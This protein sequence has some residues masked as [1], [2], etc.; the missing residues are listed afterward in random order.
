MRTQKVIYCIKAPVPL[1]APPHCSEHI[2]RAG[3]H[4]AIIV[5]SSAWAAE[6]GRQEVRAIKRAVSTHV[7]DARRA[8]MGLSAD[9]AAP[10]ATELLGNTFG[11]LSAAAFER[12]DLPERMRA[13]VKALVIMEALADESRL[14]KALSKPLNEALARVLAAAHLTPFLAV[15]FAVLVLRAAQA[16]VLGA[17]LHVLCALLLASAQIEYLSLATR[18]NGRL[19]RAAEVPHVETPPQHM[20]GTLLL[21]SSSSTSSSWRRPSRQL[22]LACSRLVCREAL[23]RLSQRCSPACPEWITTWPSTASF[24]WCSSAATLPIWCDCLTIYPCSHIPL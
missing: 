19:N 13:C 8:S 22:Y 11:S 16:F 10:I 4:G 7:I 21:A 20:Q 6:H 23:M 5:A 24:H 3:R 1:P 14:T 9:K 15:S 12:C 2:W 17:L 18:S